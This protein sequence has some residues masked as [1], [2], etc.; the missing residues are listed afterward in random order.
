M[1]RHGLCVFQSAAGFK[2]GGDARGAEGMAAD[3]DAC[4]EIGGAPLDHAPGIDAV[5][6]G[7][8]EDT[9]AADRG[10]KQGA[11]VLARE[12]GGADVFVE[13]GF[14]LVVG[15]HFVALAAFFVEA[16]PPALAIGEVVLDLH[17]DD[18]TDAGER[19]GHHPDQGAVA[20]AHDGR[21]IDAVEQDSGVIGGQHRCLA[22]LD[23]V[24][25]AAHG[26]C[27]VD[28]ED[29]AGDQPVEAHADGGEVLFDGRLG[30]AGLKHL[31]IGG[32][33]E[34]LD[35]DEFADGMPFD[36]GEE[37]G[38]GPEIGQPGI[39]VPDGGGE[40]FQEA[41][42]GGVTG[43]GDDRRHGHGGADR[44]DRF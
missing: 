40:E 12:A 23:D 39:F 31:H 11:L 2:I 10:A 41:A 37:V 38:D 7:V 34:R 1:R 32:D 43:V 19:V 9:G 26:V 24:F 20:Q 28:G 16:D 42:S 25:G 5:H 8:G 3:F 6:G 29:T 33:V 27:R 30:K 35:I 22:A 14:E 36:P 21:S 18:G 13:E 15:R 17:G 4:A 44:S